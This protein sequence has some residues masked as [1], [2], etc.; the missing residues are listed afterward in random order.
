[1]SV[2]RAA[3]PGPDAVIVGAE[4]GAGHDGRAE[5]VVTLGFAN[6]GASRLPLDTER[7]LRLMRACGAD[8]TTDLI[9]RS[10][11]DLLETLECTT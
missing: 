9:G 5:L 4:I 11:R 7:G 3:A 6:G 2:A 10:W 1:V 8:R